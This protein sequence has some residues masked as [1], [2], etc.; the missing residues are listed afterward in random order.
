[1][2][3]ERS[4]I[5]GSSLLCCARSPAWNLHDSNALNKWPPRCRGHLFWSQ[6]WLSHLDGDGQVPIQLYCEPPEVPAPLVDI[7]AYWQKSR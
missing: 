1:M 3:S 6:S 2:L 7:A 4:Q 5:F